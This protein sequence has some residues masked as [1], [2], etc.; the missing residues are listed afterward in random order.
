MIITRNDVSGIFELKQSLNNHF[1][2]KDLGHLNYLLDLEVFSYP[3]GY[4]LSQAKYA[5]DI[6]ARV[7]LTTPKLLLHHWK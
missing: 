6:L 5:S 4:Y 2:M 3:A 7:G 1:E